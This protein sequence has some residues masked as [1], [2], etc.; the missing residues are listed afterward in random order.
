[1]VNPARDASSSD[2][3]VVSWDR[4][5]ASLWTCPLPVYMVSHD[6]TPDHAFL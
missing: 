5:S 3:W 2:S 4:T 6:V 1:M